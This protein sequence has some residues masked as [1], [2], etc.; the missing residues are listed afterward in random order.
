MIQRP[1]PEEFVVRWPDGTIKPERWWS[2]AEKSMAAY[3]RREIEEW[4]E[5]RSRLWADEA[6]RN[7]DDR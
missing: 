1:K 4:Q 2:E 7:V 5:E 6:K 3:R